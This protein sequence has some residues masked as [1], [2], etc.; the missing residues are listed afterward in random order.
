MKVI[1]AGSRGFNDRQYGFMCLDH[2]HGQWP[3]TEI[4][5]GTASGADTIGEEWAV[6][7]G[8]AVRRMPADWNTHGKSAG[9]KRNVEMA[10]VGDYLIV[11]WD[12][13]SKGTQHMINI[14]NDKGITTT[15][16]HY[17]TPGC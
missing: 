2:F 15:V 4:I 16:I 1:V 10:E 17:G 7:R 9:Y 14:A 11:F 13:T 12:G 3:I 6:S 8:V 5:S